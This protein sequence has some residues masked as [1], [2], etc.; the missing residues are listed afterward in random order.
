M[1]DAATATV[2]VEAKPEAKASAPKPQPVAPSRNDAISLLAALQREARFIDIVKEPLGEYSDAQVGAAAR[3][4]LRDCGTVLDR[5]FKLEPVVEKEDG[6]HVEIPPNADA[7][8]YRVAGN[9]SADATSGS[10]VHHGWKA[11]QCELPKWTG[12]KESALVIS[13]AELEVK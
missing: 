1:G 7:A 2:D 3:D 10:L 4:V 12:A 11:K 6:E 5:L 9:A 13:P 8:Q